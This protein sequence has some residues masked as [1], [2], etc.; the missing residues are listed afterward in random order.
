MQFLLNW[1]T[2]FSTYLVQCNNHDQQQNH[3]LQLIVLWLVLER[4]AK[5]EEFIEKDNIVGCEIDGILKGLLKENTL[6]TGSKY[7]IIKNP[8]VIYSIERGNPIISSSIVIYE[9]FIL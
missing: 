8:L 4:I 2:F 5:T 9:S 6:T 1:E 7:K 3:P